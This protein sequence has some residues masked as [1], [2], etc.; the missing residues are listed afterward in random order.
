[1]NELTLLLRALFGAILRAVL[2]AAFEAAREAA[3]DTAEDSRPQPELRA[4]LQGRVRARWGRAGA[5][6]ALALCV[7]ALAGCGVKT[8]Y[9]PDGEAVRLRQPVKRAKIWVMDAN[10][11]PRPSR[12][13]IPEGWYALPVPDADAPQGGTPTSTPNR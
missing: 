10:G 12:M 11:V 1:M 4:R 6:G 2:P 9:V 13:T 7:L 8:I 3:R 5:A